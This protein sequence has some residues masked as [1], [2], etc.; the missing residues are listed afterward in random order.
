MEYFNIQ[1]GSYGVNV[2]FLVEGTICYIVDP[3]QEG[4]RIIEIL[5][6]KGLSPKGILLTHAHFDHI[7]GT[8]ELQ[9]A[10]PELPLYVHPADVL[11]LNHPLNSAP[12]D[13]PKIKEPKN[14]KDVKELSF[15]EVIET[16]GHTPGGVCY[17]LKDLKL[18]LSGDTLFQLS[19]GRTDFPGGDM[20]AMMNS[21]R[22][23]AA[24]P[25][26]TRVIPGHGDFTTI[27]FE[28]EANP[29]LQGR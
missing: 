9:A 14:I 17:Y 13:Y 19:I 2:T 11:I 6:T 7:G 23:L 12:P 16:P 8:N 26:D 24:L 21:L 29:Y 27:G 25:D 1:V 4:K 15:L 5:K 18:L 10:Y 22:K 3:G 20:L 28:K